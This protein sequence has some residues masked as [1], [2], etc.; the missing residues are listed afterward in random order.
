MDNLRC[1]LEPYGNTKIMVFY[2]G[3]SDE[4]TVALASGRALTTA[5]RRHFSVVGM[6]LIEAVI[7]DDLCP[8]SMVVFPALHGAFGEDGGIQSLLE[9]QGV[10][11]A[12]SDSS[13]SRLCMDKPASKQRVAAAGVRIAPGF[14][15]EAKEATAS[16]PTGLK[17]LQGPFVLKPADGG[18]S[19]GLHQ[20]LS[21]AQLIGLLPRLSKGRWMVETH[22]RGR[23]ITVGILEGR[24]LGLVEVVPGGDGVYDFE[25]KYT[26][27]LTD[28]R[29]PAVVTPAIEA[30]IKQTAEGV[31]AACGC[32]DFARVDFIL[33][34]E[35][36]CYFLEINTMPGLT[37]T[38]L[39]PKSAA[40]CGM[41]FT[42]LC[43][44]LMT[45]ALKRL[46]Q[47]THGNHLTQQKEISANR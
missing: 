17:A 21:Q 11:Y 22:I 44:Q 38:S 1:S 36:E 31:F 40:C 5:L 33:T 28:Y 20:N 47:T 34:N 19:L 10:V 42:A 13:S 26:K 30:E 8:E 7:P 14:D 32:R 6:D 24:A 16:V 29:F 23:E 27:G 18:S 35:G 3:I 45:P 9:A 12:G 15:F 41:D 46:Q 37:E 4:R 43:L 2:G 39:L 25:H